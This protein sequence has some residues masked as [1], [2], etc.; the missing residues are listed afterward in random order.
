[1]DQRGGPVT[2]MPCPASP[3]NGTVWSLYM[4]WRLSPCG[5]Q[6]P[7]EAALRGRRQSN[8]EDRSPH[9]CPPPVL[10]HGCMHR[11]QVCEGLM[12][13]SCL[14]FQ[15]SLALGSRGFEAG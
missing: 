13:V 10:P 4:V 7:G 3:G 6:L 15:K 8:G 1:M 5:F 11:S 12:W 9:Q 14:V 2:L